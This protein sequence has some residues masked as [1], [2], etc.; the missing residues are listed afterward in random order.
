MQAN[1]NKQF[2]TPLLD[3][4]SACVAAKSKAPALHEK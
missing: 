1:N 4:N 2:N 3:V